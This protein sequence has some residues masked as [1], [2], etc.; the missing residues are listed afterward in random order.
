MAQFMAKQK[1]STPVKDTQ[2]Q[3]KAKVEK[4]KR[5]AA[6]VVERAGKK[7]ASQ[8][9]TN[10]LKSA[11]EQAKRRRLRLKQQQLRR[12]QRKNKKTDGLPAGSPGVSAFSEASLKEAAEDGRTEAMQQQHLEALA[13][14]MDPAQMS[15]IEHIVKFMSSMNGQGSFDGFESM[16]CAKQKGNPLFEF[17]EQHDST[18][19]RLYRAKL[20]TALKIAAVC[21]GEAAAAA[22]PPPPPPPPSTPWTPSAGDGATE[23]NAAANAT[24]GRRR[25]ANRWGPPAA[26]GP[27]AAAG[28]AAAVEPSAP[29]AIPATGAARAESQGEQDRRAKQMAEQKEMQFLEQRIREMRESGGAGGDRLADLQDARKSHYTQ[30]KEFGEKDTRDTVDDA[31][32]GVIEG[33]TWEHRKRAM[34]MKKTADGAFASTV[35]GRGKHGVNSYMPPEVLAKFMTDAKKKASGEAVEGDEDYSGNKIDQSNIGFQML[36]GAGWE[37]GKGLGAGGKGIV[38]PVNAGTSSGTTNAGVGQEATH[39]V[40]QGDD[41]FMQ[42]RKRMMMAYRFRP[43]PLNNPRRKYY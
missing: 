42:Y 11:A 43:N 38:A 9:A 35:A 3:E 33:G 6:A 20:A 34:E 27:E 19:Y 12:Q 18:A 4:R 17:L 21:S 23:G 39:E 22:A 41:M 1:S 24:S 5:E 30:F 8:A 29:S 26:S 15:T 14:Q 36:K 37:E 25:K 16:L 13:E 7:Q 31:E 28:A 10:Q 40:K 2:A 32:D